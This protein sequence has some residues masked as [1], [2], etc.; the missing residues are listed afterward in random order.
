MQAK[1]ELDP[2]GFITIYVDSSNAFNAADRA[3]MLES[4]YSDSRLSHLWRAY[5]F[6]YA[7][8]SHLLLRQH[9]AVVD[10]ISS[11]Q[12]GRQGCVLAGLG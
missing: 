12:G 8:P 9:G 7:T 2:E 10:S 3:M 5:A 4:V 11:A 1:T 6:C